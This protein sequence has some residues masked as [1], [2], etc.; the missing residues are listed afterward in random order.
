ML[1][2]GSRAIDTFIGEQ[3]MIGRDHGSAFLRIMALR[4]QAGCATVVAIDPTE[5][6]LR[7]I[8]AYK[9]AGFLIDSTFICK[10]G[11]GVSDAIQKLMQR[12]VTRRSDPR[13]IERDSD[14]YERHSNRRRQPPS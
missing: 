11:P 3:T 10:E 9:N 8:R 12:L 5:P 2:I 1:P 4:L 13:R 14:D 6:N 7:A